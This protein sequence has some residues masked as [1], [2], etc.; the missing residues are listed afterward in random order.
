MKIS[1]IGAGNVGSALAR[2]LTETGHDVTTSNTA[3]P[4]A[5][6]ATQAAAAEL[7]VLAVP[8]VAV[9]T[10][11]DRVKAALSGKI[12]VD[13]TN[14]LAA[15]FMSLTV[16]YT[17]SGGEQVA[18]ALPGAIVVKAFNSVFA[19]NLG[20]P[21]A[22]GGKLFLPVAGDD[23]TARKT[24]VELGTQLGFD[25]VDAGPLANARYLEPVIELLIQ[26]AYGHGMGADIGLVLTRG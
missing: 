8:F 14:P 22:G 7:V 4:P 21:D 16:G 13:A 10:L 12:V 26:L 6:V 20:T 3:T 9:V 1:V 5:E 24:V 25:A 2:R 15:D 17:T 11:D 19:S 23:E 18:A